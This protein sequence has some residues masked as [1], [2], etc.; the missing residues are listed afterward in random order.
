M[1]KVTIED[2]FEFTYNS[3]IL[4][5]KG[6]R[7]WAMT[8]YTQ[9]LIDAGLVKAFVE[10]GISSPKNFTRERYNPQ[11]IAYQVTKRMEG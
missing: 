7:G 6:W 9:F 3:K 11:W 2:G 1:P 10:S 8:K 5:V 4:I